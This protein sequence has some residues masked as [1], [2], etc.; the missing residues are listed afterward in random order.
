VLDRFAI[1][2]VEAVEDVGQAKL[3]E[4]RCQLG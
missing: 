4:H 1:A 3:L 2:A